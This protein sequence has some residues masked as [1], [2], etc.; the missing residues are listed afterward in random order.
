MTTMDIDQV[1][2]LVDRLERDI[3]RAGANEADTRKLLA[4]IEAIKALLR[5]PAPEHSRLRERLHAI[6]QELWR[7]AP[8]LAEIGRILG[9]T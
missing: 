2:K 1:A 7:D 3:A 9:M 6:R 5:S 4:E 8:Y